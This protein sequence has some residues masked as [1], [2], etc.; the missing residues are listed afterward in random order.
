M[1]VQAV[2]NRPRPADY[3]Q[4]QTPKAEE[5]NPLQRD[6]NR[7]GSAAG[8]RQERTGHG[9]RD[10]R[11]EGFG[12]RKRRIDAEED[13][14][15]EEEQREEVRARH[16]RQRLREGNESQARPALRHVSDADPLLRGHE[17]EDGE[18]G[19]R[20]YQREHRVGDADKKGILDDVLTLGIERR[21]STH[22]DT[23][24][25]LSVQ[26]RGTAAAATSPRR[27]GRGKGGREGENERKRGNDFNS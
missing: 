18:D 11:A 14:H 23:P 3:A 13:Q 5:Q 9:L 16:H 7:L 8:R 6:E 15:E 24:S 26:A 27:P 10:C 1:A 25:E 20:G 21:L 17:A 22:D 2:R 4:E 19:H 12:H